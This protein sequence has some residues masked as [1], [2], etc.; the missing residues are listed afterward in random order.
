MDTSCD[1]GYDCEKCPEC[2]RPH[3]ECECDYE[4]YK[5]NNDNEELEDE[6]NFDW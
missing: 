5:T 3:C 1:C 2:G 4:E 6:R